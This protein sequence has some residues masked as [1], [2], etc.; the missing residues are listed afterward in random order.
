MAVSDQIAAPVSS[1]FLAPSYDHHDWFVGHDDTN[2]RAVVDPNKPAAV[3]QKNVTAVAL[4]SHYFTAAVADKSGLRPEF[5]ALPVKKEGDIFASTGFV[6]YVPLTK[7]S[8][9]QIEQIWYVGPKDVDHL[10]AAD[11][12]VCDHCRAAFVVAALFPFV[13]WELGLRYYWT[14]DRRSWP[15]SALQYLFV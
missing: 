7:G 10:R 5:H 13:V 4:S 9:F 6:D 15:G 2:T 1:S 12:S 8:D 11:E 3:D 14:D